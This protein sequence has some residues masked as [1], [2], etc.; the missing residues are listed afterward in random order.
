MLKLFVYVEAVSKER[1]FQNVLQN[2]YLSVPLHLLP[3]EDV[4][5]NFSTRHLI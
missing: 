1:A 4:Y 2:T 5:A 3:W